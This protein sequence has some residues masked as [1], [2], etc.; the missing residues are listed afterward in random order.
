M[1]IFTEIV[2]SLL[3]TT[4]LNVFFEFFKKLAFVELT[5]LGYLFNFFVN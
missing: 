5:R 1:N 3:N 4:G 2:I